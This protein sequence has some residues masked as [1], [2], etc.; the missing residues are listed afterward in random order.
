MGE[1]YPA[2]PLLRRFVELGVPLTT[3]S[4]AHGGAEVADRSDEL[5]AL[6]DGAGVAELQAFR[7]RRPHPVPVAGATV[8][9]RR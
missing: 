5:R 8:G 4:D 3:A 1:E 7:G 6:L 2:P 9:G